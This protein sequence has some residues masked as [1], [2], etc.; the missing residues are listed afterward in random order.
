[1]KNSRKKPNE[2]KIK[3]SR[4]KPNEKHSNIFLV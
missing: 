2:K 3:T 1:M 4:K